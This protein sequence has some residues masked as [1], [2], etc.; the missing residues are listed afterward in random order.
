MIPLLVNS[1][2]FLVAKLIRTFLF[3]FSICFLAFLHW[4]SICSVNNSS[5]LLFLAKTQRGRFESLVVVL[6]AMFSFKSFFCFPVC[7]LLDGSSVCSLT[8]SLA[9]VPR[10]N[11]SVLIRVC[12]L[13]FHCQFFRSFLLFSFTCRSSCVFYCLVHHFHRSRSISNNDS[14]GC[15]HFCS[16]Q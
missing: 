5:L 7:S 6:L 11:S 9:V 4:L 14:F 13:F 12:F 8:F 16:C 15:C 2:A 1:D 3:W 10:S